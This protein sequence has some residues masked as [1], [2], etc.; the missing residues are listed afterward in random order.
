MTRIKKYYD[1]INPL[2][3]PFRFTSVEALRKRISLDYPEI[4]KL[5]STSIVYL[6]LQ[7]KVKNPNPKLVEI[8]NN[9]KISERPYTV[10]KQCRK[11]LYEDS[12]AYSISDK[13]TVFC[14]KECIAEYVCHDNISIVNMSVVLNTNKE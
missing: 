7:N 9:V 8:L 14:S 3:F 10:C 2:G 1:Y 5:L 11:A 4:G 6:Y 12:T 13:N